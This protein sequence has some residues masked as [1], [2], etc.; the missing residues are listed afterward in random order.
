[1][2]EHPVET[3]IK[4][5]FSNHDLLEEALSTAASISTNDPR[6]G[7]QGNKRLALLG[8]S[9]L[10]ECILEA[11]YETEERISKCIYL[12]FARETH[13]SRRRIRRGYRLS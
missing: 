13:F 11:W 4:Y 8:D 1:M 9:V 5:Q 3:I 10:R 2:S 7:G 6:D 12:K